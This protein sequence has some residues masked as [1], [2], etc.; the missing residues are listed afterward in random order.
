[1]L[2][3]VR[4]RT[5][6]SSRCGADPAFEPFDIVLLDPPYDDAGPIDGR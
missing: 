5:R 6:R 2:S 3:S 4:R 1:M